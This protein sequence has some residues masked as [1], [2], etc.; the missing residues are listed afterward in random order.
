MK[1]R[2]VMTA[3]PASVPPEATMRDVARLLLQR[4]ISAVPVVD[5]RG[6]VLGMVSEGDL[7]GRA[8]ADRDA[9]RDWWLELLAEGEAL[10]PAFLEELRRRGRPV[11][12]I[13]ATPVVTVV[14]DTELDEIARLLTTH[15][16]KR[17]PVVRDGRLVGIVSRAD[18]LH[19]MAA[20]G[21]PGE[22]PAHHGLLA[23]AIESLDRHFHHRPPAGTDAPALPPAATHAAPVRATDFRTLV[24]DFRQQ[25]AS[26]RDAERRAQAEQRRQRVARLIEEHVSDEGWRALL[27]HARRAAEHGEAEFMLLRFPSQL[28][29]DRGRAIN[30]SEARWPATLRGEAAEIYLRW[31]HD[32][33]PGGFRLDAR[34][35]DFPGGLP[36]D[37]GLFLAWDR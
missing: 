31:E 5:P 35:L 36:G 27:D 15:R 7:L 25:E 19:A 21:G 16:V 13:M 18:L 24:A 1:A 4:G 30:V 22:A 10:S 32:L 33:R 12:E 34:I 9:R 11:R 28:C 37:V 23:D 17:V 14:E 26:H 20:G 8:E 6:A 29:S 2:D 3:D